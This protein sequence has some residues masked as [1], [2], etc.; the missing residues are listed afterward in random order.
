MYKKFLIKFSILVTIFGIIG[1][2]DNVYAYSKDG[3]SMEIDSVFYEMEDGVWISSENGSMGIEIEENTKS[4]IE[5]G[6]ALREYVKKMKEE[7]GDITIVK[8]EYSE[9]NGYKCLYIQT[10]PPGVSIAKY[11]VPTK[12]KIYMISLSGTDDDIF[13]DEAKGMIETFKIDDYEEPVIIET[14]DF[15][16]EEIEKA[17]NKTESQ[18]NDNMTEKKYSI[19]AIVVGIVVIGFIITMFF[20]RKK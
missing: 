17:E 2:L 9:I 16:I 11:I 6:A 14:N 20:S 10:A 4:K 13:S 19:V 3:M 12:N 1:L 18:N 8:A 15:S 5:T 7:L